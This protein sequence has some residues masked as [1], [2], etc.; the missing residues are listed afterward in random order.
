N[1]DIER[2]S[3]Y[4]R[5]NTVSHKAEGLFQYNLRG[6]LSFEVL[7][8][9]LASHDAWGS[10]ISQELDKYRSNLANF[11]VTYDLSDRVKLRVDYANFLV[12]YTASRNAFRD[13]DDNVISGYVYYKFKPKTALFAEYEFADIEY[14][15]DVLSNSME[16]HYYGGLQWD[17]TAKTKGSVKAGYGVKDFRNP[18]IDTGDYFIMEAQMDYAFTPK[19]SLML[20]GARKTEETNISTTNYIVSNSV[21]LEYLQRLTAKILGDI[22]LYYAHDAYKGDLTF[23]GETKERKDRYFSGALAFQYKFREW[24][25]M[26]AGYVYSL[27]DSSFS[28]FDYTNNTVFLRVIGS[29]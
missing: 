12:N 22:R 14:R 17:I 9:F 10:G 3:K 18:Q 15:N 28:D 7:D 19:T 13:R 23:F 25:E 24:L 4:S 26:D 11:I 1:A 2:Y 16:H 20:K 5:G 8:Q 27:R 6:G 21:E 29:L